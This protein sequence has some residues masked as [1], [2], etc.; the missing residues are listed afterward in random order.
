MHSDATDLRVRWTDWASPAEGREVVA[1]FVRMFQ[2]FDPA[3][4]CP[5]CL[6]PFGVHHLC[7]AASP[8]AKAPTD[9]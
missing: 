2:S 7:P 6:W 8:F 9:E 5:V 3:P 1:D 4:P